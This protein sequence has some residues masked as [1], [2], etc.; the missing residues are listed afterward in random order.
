MK[1]AVK[2]SLTPGPRHERGVL[3]APNIQRYI[4]ADLF[5]SAGATN[6]N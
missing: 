4:N 2:E 1:L 3:Q 6:P 5:M